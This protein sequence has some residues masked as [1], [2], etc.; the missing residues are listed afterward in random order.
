MV[1]LTML[2]SPTAQ[3]SP[4]PVH[5]HAS[6]GPVAA[7]NAFLCNFANYGHR[8]SIQLSNLCAMC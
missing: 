3:F 2:S 5:R 4:T 8:N 1:I 7:S 6:V